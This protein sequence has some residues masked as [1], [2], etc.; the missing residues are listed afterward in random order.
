MCA[1]P[2]SCPYPDP[3]TH[4]VMLPN[5][6]DCNTFYMCSNGN[7]IL[8]PC[9]PGLHFNDDLQ[10]C[11]Y[12]ER[13]NCK[14]R[15]IPLGEDP[16]GQ[17]TP[18]SCGTDLGETG[19]RCSLKCDGNYQLR[20]SAYVDCTEEGWNSTNGN[21]TPECVPVDCIG[22][23]IEDELNK[24]LS[25]NAS[26]LFVLDESGSVSEPD[27]EK[28]KEFV[29]DIISAFPLS[30]NRSAGVITFSD[31]SL[32][33]IRLSESST[34]SFMTQVDAINYRSGGTDILDGLQ[35][36]IKE[37]NSNRVHPLTLVFLITDGV[38]STDGTPA[39]DIIKANNNPLFAIGVASTNLV[40]L[41]TLASVGTNGIRHF[42]HT[43]NYDVL[44]SIGEYINRPVGS[45][46]SSSN[47]TCKNP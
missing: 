13:A 37:I 38:S 19:D 23:I 20:G 40:H 25:V 34:A 24:T 16:N 36:A 33:R 7:P 30:E 44:K 18:A 29:K 5:Y 15:C 42:F 14:L 8:M 45:G 9:P 12:P 1:Q 31:S 32:V 2:S 22:E 10:V 11:D 28:T 47:S 21:F 27:F 39:A 46:G 4:T 3:I 17:W 26:L 43:R 41:E 6:A 35:T